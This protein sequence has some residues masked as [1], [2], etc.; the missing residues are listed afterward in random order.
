MILSFEPVLPSVDRAKDE[1]VWIHETGVDGQETPVD[2][3]QATPGVQ[4]VTE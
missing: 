4:R 2:E 3:E 1:S